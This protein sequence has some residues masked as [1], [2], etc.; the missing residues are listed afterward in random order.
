MR[1]NPLS[2]SR[3]VRVF[4][5]KSFYWFCAI[6]PYPRR[7]RSTPAKPAIETCCLVRDIFGILCHSRVFSDR[8]LHCPFCLNKTKSCLWDKSAHTACRCR[9]CWRASGALAFKLATSAKTSSSHIALLEG[10]LFWLP[11]NTLGESVLKVDF[12]VIFG[13]VLPLL[14]C[15]LQRFGGVFVFWQ[16]GRRSRRSV[17]NPAAPSLKQSS[18]LL[19]GGP[20]DRQ[21][22]RLHFA[23]C[24]LRQEQGGEKMFCRGGDANLLATEGGLFGMHFGMEA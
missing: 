17:R 11:R 6:L 2:Q 23:Q 12:W 14:P 22:S 8:H 9:A 19:S 1:Q 15:R 21:P 20:V 18:A 4:L 13:C 10:V 5:I 24:P 16:R 7:S 3:K